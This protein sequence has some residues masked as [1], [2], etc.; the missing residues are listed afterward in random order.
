ML[1]HT[2]EKMPKHGFNC[3]INANI[4]TVRFDNHPKESLHVI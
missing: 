4:V 3:L 1:S 2:I